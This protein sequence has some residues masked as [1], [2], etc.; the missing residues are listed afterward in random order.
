MRTIRW[1]N[2]F[3]KDFKRELS[4]R[5]AKS[6]E[7]ELATVLRLLANDVSLPARYRD[8]GLSGDWAKHRDCHLRPDL[9]MIYSIEEDGY[10]DLIRLGSH[11]ELGF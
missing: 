7:P 2:R 11:S 1:A 10:L 9:V 6:L 4:G 8:N 3:K 5:H